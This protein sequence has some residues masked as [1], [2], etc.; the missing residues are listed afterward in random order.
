MG[1]LSKELTAKK[2]QKALMLLNTDMLS[3]PKVYLL[4][5][6]RVII[7]VVTKLSRALFGGVFFLLPI[8]LSSSSPAPTD[9]VG[10]NAIVMTTTSVNLTWTRPTDNGGQN[11]SQYVIKYGILD[12]NDFTNVTNTTTMATKIL[13]SGLT[14]NSWYL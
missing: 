9:V 12:G 2:I 7:R 3:G 5:N 1:V 10:L 8:I 6:F 11:I 13:L 14:P 4:T